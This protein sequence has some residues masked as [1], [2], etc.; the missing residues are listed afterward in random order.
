[1]VDAK[2][3][4]FLSLWVW[5]TSINAWQKGNRRKPEVIPEWLFPKKLTSGRIKVDQLD[6][7][8][9]L[10]LPAIFP[11]I[12]MGKAGKFLPESKII[13]FYKAKYAW[14]KRWSRSDVFRPTDQIEI[15][16]QNYHAPLSWPDFL[17]RSLQNLCYDDE[18]RE[19][20][21]PW[22]EGHFVCACSV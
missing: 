5:G 15:V 4:R 12:S 7:W 22:A 13:G 10:K 6:L 8:G 16:L 19:T 1:M 9:S 3:S 11:P 2:I 21:L 17:S 20:N 18:P 14:D